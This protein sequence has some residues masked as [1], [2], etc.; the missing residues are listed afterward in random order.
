MPTKIVY[1]V[2]HGESLLNEQGIRQGREGGLSQKGKSQVRATAEGLAH[3]KIHFDAIISSPYERTVETAH[4][5]AERLNMPVEYS[6]LLTERKNPT[7]IIGKHKDAPEVRAITDR[8]D[9]SFHEDGLRYS[10]EENFTDLKKRAR[11]LLKYIEERPE[12]KL[13]MVTHGIFLKMFVCYML[14]GEKMKAS[15]Y[16]R[17]SYESEMDN[18]GVVICSYTTYWF[19]KPKWRLLLWNGVPTRP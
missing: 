8:I 12:N 15:D 19:R 2:R 16:V 17:L 6:E 5:I 3:E 9:N 14:Y 13:L 10:D 4:I 18:A 1:F 11:N 7:E